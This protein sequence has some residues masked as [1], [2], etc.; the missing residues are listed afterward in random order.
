MRFIDTSSVSVWNREEE[1][2]IDQKSYFQWQRLLEIQEIQMGLMEEIAD[3][4]K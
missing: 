1:M 4:K 3:K 2:G